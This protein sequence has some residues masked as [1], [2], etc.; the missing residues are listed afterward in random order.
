MNS[1][2]IRIPLLTLL[3]CYL[4]LTQVYRF[5]HVH[6]VETDDG[7]NIELSIH[8]VHHPHDDDFGHDDHQEEA[9][10]LTGDWDHIY[11]SNI[12]LPPFHSV[13]TSYTPKPNILTQLILTEP[14]TGPPPLPPDFATPFYRGPPLS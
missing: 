3:F 13:I 6:A 1:L 12:Q 2:Y 8:H 5:V 4:A 10:H 14:R 11:S 9:D 7:Y